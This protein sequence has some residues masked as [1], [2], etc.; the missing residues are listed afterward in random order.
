MTSREEKP[1]LE[2]ML[3]TY[4]ALW[5]ETD[6]A[7]RGELMTKCLDE[8]VEIV[9]PGYFARGYRE[10]EEHVARFQREQPGST[11]T[12]ASGIDAHT[13]WARFAVNVV[14]PDG[15]V[16][17]RALD[18]VEFGSDRRIRR[19]IAFWGAL[20]GLPHGSTPRPDDALF[21]LEV[22]DDVPADL[23]RIIDEGLGEENERAAPMG[24]V[25]SLACFARDAS[26]EVIGGTVG[27]TWGECC[28]LQEL[29]VAPAARRAG[30]GARLVQRF[31]EHARTRGCRTFYLDTFS[32]QAP[33]FYRKLGYVPVLE[34]EGFTQDIVFYSMMKRLDPRV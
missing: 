19:L 7:R 33:A 10:V 17:A 16:I 2:A 6:A 30:V 8:D 20:P 24:D 13:D 28:Q 1:V 32:F 3:R 25:Q 21:S 14:A 26:G 12:L 34:V 27:R 23:A 29:W 31:E 5:S 9:G 15:S 22:H 18:I 11:P 4:E